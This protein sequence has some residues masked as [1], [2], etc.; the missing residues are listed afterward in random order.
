MHQVRK[1]V[2][3]WLRLV[4][5]ETGLDWSKTAKNQSRVVQSGFLTYWDF[6]GLVSVLVHVPER[7]KPDLTGL[8]S[9]TSGA[10]WRIWRVMWYAYEEEVSPMAAI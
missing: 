7:K 9:T 5:T 10:G 3:N 2:I 6:G 4:K 8:P 1:P